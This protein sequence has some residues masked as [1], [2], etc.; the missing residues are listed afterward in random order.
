MQVCVCVYACR[1]LCS[2]RH[3]YL[4]WR[5]GGPGITTRGVY[6]RHGQWPPVAP[7]PYVHF[8]SVCVCTCTET[9]S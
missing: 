4:E 9:D 7:Y 8:F 3:K 6:H 1:G 2:A 5:R